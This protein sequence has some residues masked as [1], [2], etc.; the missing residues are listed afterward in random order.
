MLYNST[1]GTRENFKGFNFFC[2]VGMLTTKSLYKSSLFTF[3]FYLNRNLR[4]T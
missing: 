4:S 1:T 2:G 3:Y